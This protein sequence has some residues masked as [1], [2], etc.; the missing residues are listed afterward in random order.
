[1]RPLTLLLLLLLSATPTLDLLAQEPM[2]M[3]IMTYN[4][5]NLFDLRHDSLKD[6]TDYLPRRRPA[7][8]CTTLPTAN[9]TT[10][11]ASSSP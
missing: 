9:W 1:M 8:E 10:S 3:R 4:V 6:D 2:C 7:M 11:P 5:E